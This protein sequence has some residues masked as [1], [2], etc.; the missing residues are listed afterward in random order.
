MRIDS[1]P[2]CLFAAPDGA[3][4]VLV[5]EELHVEWG[6]VEEARAEGDEPHVERDTEQDDGQRHSEYT[7]PAHSHRALTWV[8]S[9]RPSHLVQLKLI[10]CITELYCRA[11]IVNY[12][13]FYL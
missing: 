9:G 4:G 6:E 7:K 12:I 5:V 3:D 11:V 13:Q 8:T 2:E 1:L 10:H